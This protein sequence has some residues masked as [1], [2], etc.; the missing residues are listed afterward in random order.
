ML[1]KEAANGKSEKQNPPSISI[2]HSAVYCR[3]YLN[4]RKL[5]GTPTLVSAKSCSGDNSAKS[6]LLQSREIWHG[7]HVLL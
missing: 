6:K 2:R 1:V 5:L 4:V 3:G 7:K